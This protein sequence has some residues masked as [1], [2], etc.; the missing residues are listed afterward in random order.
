MTANDNP[1]ELQPIPPQA[2]FSPHL[3]VEFLRIIGQTIS[4]AS[5]DGPND[6]GMQYDSEGDRI[7]WLTWPG[8]HYW[9][10]TNLCTIIK[11]KLVVEVGTYMGYSA[12]ALASN[13]EQVVTYD[14][15][16]V[17]TYSQTMGNFFSSF[18]NVEQRIGNLL[19]TEYFES[20]SQTISSADLIFL[21]G[22]KDG[23]FEYSVLPKILA[24]A[25]IGAIII[26]DDVRFKNMTELWESVIYPKMDI[27]SFAHSTGTGFIMKIENSNYDQV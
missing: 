5:S 4:L 2:I 8:E 16:P 18:H 3:P 13:S 10:L 6:Q 11:P 12:I 14:I 19:S 9:F 24:V 17:S 23:H 25:K 1:H 15:E 7:F 21:D 26:L 22:P 27:G 20:Q